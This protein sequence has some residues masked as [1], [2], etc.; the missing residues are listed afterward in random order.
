MSWSAV[1]NWLFS[2]RKGAFAWAFTVLTSASLAL[3]MW[4]VY[5]SRDL[6]VNPWVN[7]G[8]ALVTGYVY[9]VGFVTACGVCDL[10]CNAW[11]NRL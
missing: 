2:W 5:A 8:F 6:Y 11:R 9:G 1:H 4:Q 10:D 7:L 3:D